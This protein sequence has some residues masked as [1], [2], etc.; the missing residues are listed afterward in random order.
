MANSWF[1]FK[2]FLVKQES[3]AMK[4][5]TDSCVFGATV[6]LSSEIKNMLDI[7]TGTGLL[8]LMLAQR[9]ETDVRIDAVEMNRAA[10]QQA[11]DNF[12]NSPWNDRI[13]LHECSIQEY[14]K[15]TPKQYDLIICNPPF[16]SASL[17]TG[18][19]S[20]D[21][22]LHQSH[23]LID[24]LMQVI[25]F[26]LKQSGDAYLLISIYEEGNFINAADNVGLHVHRFQSMYDNE[27]KL[28]RY[29]LHLR[30]DS[31]HIKNTEEKFVIRNAENQYT[32][33]FIAALKDFY[34]NL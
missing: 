3:A 22:A 17:K 1:Q 26:M 29:V 31:V 13:K 32:E 2:Q 25:Y 30:K 14:F 33:Q 23:L 19:T 18:N 11:Q 20:K 24:E 8:A 4:V 16:F 12:F 10:A 7:G 27:S 9:T 6:P 34:L 5:C 21:M 15:F 28:I